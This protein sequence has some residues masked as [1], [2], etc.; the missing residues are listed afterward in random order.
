MNFIIGSYVEIRHSNP[1]IKGTIVAEDTSI[2]SN[3]YLIR[4]DS[5]RNDW[6]EAR[7]EKLPRGIEGIGGWLYWIHKDYLHELE[8][9]GYEV[10]CD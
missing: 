3:C 2:Y 9:D 7:G 5:I 1:F 4:A 8:L 10:D 6:P